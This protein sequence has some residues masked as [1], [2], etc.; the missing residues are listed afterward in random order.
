MA[1]CADRTQE[2][3]IEDLRWKQ[4]MPLALKQC[5]K[6]VIAMINGAAFGAGLNLA[7]ACDFRLAAETATFGTAFVKIGFSGDF[8]RS[9]NRGPPRGDQGLHRETPAGLLRALKAVA[10][11]EFDPSASICARLEAQCA[12]AVRLSCSTCRS[13]A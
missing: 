8:G 1:L 13:L 11:P 4:R 10:A 5:P 3:R 6:P 2:Q 7:L 12:A 9:Y